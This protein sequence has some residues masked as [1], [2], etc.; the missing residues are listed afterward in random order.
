[1]KH[2]SASINCC[3]A[4]RRLRTRSLHQPEDVAV[5]AEQVESAALVGGSCESAKDVDD[6]PA[7]E[8]AAAN[9][10][11]RDV[12]TP[13]LIHGATVCL[14]GPAGELMGLKSTTTGKAEEMALLPISTTTVEAGSSRRIQS[15]PSHSIFVVSQQVRRSVLSIPNPSHRCCVLRL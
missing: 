6:D 15:Y 3:V 13:S 2:S 1:M 10:A 8:S 9:S 11:A 5:V 7:G 4:Y 12:Q 14:V